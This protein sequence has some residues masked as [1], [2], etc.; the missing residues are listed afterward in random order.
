MP[1]FCKIWKIT[2][3]SIALLFFFQAISVFAQDAETTKSG[4]YS[5][6]KCC[7][8][9]VSFD[10]CVCNEAKEIKAYVEA[11]IENGVTQED[12]FYKV[13]KKFSLNIIQDPE[14]KQAVEKKLIKETGQKRPQV[15]LE[16]EDFNFGAVHKKQGKVSKIFKL[17]NKGNVDLIITNIRVSCSCVTASLKVASNRSPYFGIAGAGPGWQAV[18]K[19]QDSAELEVVLDLA[20]PSMAV[21]K[22]ARD[23]FIASNDP[24]YPEK[25]LRVE[26][27]VRD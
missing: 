23:I 19:P 22:Q 3:S 2:L 5:K 17:Q 15:I 27:E 9:K 25:A 13:A 26:A 21:G 7:P 6:L 8:C 12:I 20:S 1:Y 4:I 11:L 24:L 16:P 14:I 10:K 18:I